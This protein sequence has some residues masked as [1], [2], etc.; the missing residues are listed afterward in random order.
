[1]Y[2]ESMT[3][4]TEYR[5]IVW[6]ASGDYFPEVA[7]RFD[8][9]SDADAFALELMGDVDEYVNDDTRAVWVEDVI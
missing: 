7:G 3:T 8:N 6:E 4:T 1:M 9:L 2:D 5:Y